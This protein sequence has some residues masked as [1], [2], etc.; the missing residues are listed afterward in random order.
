M[1][2]KGIRVKS[3]NLFFDT[4]EKFNVLLS[5]LQHNRIEKQ[6][7]SEYLD[8]DSE[9]DDEYTDN[10]RQCG[11]VLKSYEETDDHQSNYIQCEKCNVCF[12]NKFQWED[13]VKC[14]IF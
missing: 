11:V 4:N 12:H 3:A 8:S 5:G 7:D 6:N 13:H 2:P 14:D 1:Q 9:D 10:C